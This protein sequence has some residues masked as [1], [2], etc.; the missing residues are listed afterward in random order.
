MME[1]HKSEQSALIIKQSTS[2]NSGSLS[3]SIDI[4]LKDITLLHSNIR[5]N[6]DK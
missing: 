5:I 3:K 4:D 2:K 6:S 1:E